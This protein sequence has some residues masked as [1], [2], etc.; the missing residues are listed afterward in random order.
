MRVDDGEGRG[1]HRRDAVVVG[2]DHVDPAGIALGHLGHDDV[3][4]LLQAGGVDHL[5]SSLIDAL[6]SLTRGLPL[7]I[8]R[9]VL[10]PAQCVR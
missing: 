9:T 5:D 10:A 4:A 3:V 1:E 6:V 2:D 8:E 7:A